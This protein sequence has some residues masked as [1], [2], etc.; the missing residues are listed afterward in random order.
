MTDLPPD[1]VAKAMVDPEWSR[2]VRLDLDVPGLRT[3]DPTLLRESRVLVPVDVQALYVPQ[4]SAE[5]FVRL[6]FA[7]TAPDG[8]PPEPMPEP[9]D[10]GAPRPPGVHLHWALPDALLRGNVDEDRLGLPLLPD[11]WVVLRLVAPIGS[12]TPAV[13]GWVL[14]SDT[15]RVT[16]L[17]DWDGQP[18]GAPRLGRTLTRLDGAA[19]GSIAWT[20]GY[21]ATLGRFAL[22]DPLDGLPER[23]AWHDLATYLVAGWWSEPTADPLDGARTDTS[24]HVRLAE[25]GWSLTTEAEG[26]DED[27]SLLALRRAAFID[28]ANRYSPRVRGVTAKAAGPVEQTHPF[29]PT[30]STLADYAA[31]VLGAEP[32]WPRSTLLHGAVHGVP[33]S[34]GVVAD[35]RPSSGVLDVAL[36]R[37]GDDVAVTLAAAGLG[38]SA[39][40]RSLERVLSAFTGQLLPRLGTPDGLVDVDE[41][42]HAAG[43]LALP[44]GDGGVERVSAVPV[45]VSRP[46]PPPPRVKWAGRSRTEL[47]PPQVLREV[48]Q[49]WEPVGAPVGGEV[50]EVRQPAP[51]FHRPLEP[52]VAV[53]GPRRSLRHGGDGRFS[54]DGN[55]L[56][57]WP[58]Q[59]VEGY[60]QLVDGARLLP[61]VGSGAVPPEVDALARE[62]LTQSPYLRAWLADVAHAQHDLDPERVAARLDAEVLLRFGRQ[63]VYDGAT[64]A[65]GVSSTGSGRMVA[66]ELRRFSLV[67][68]VDSSPV[69]VTAWTQPWVPLW[70]EWTA[71]VEVSDRFDGWSLEAVDLSPPGPLSAPVRVLTGRSPLHDGT[72]STLAR[73]IEAWAVAEDALDLS[74]SGEADEATEAS[75]SGL[76]DAIGNLDVLTAGLDV[77][78]RLLGL[79]ADRLRTRAPDGTLGHVTPVADPLLVACG[80]L[81]LTAAR[82][83]DAFG[84]TLDLPTARVPARDDASGALLLRP[85]LTRPARWLF[86]FTSP[87]DDAEASAG[88]ASPVAGF[89]LPDHLDEALEVFDAAGQPVGQLMDVGGVAWEIA[90]G[91]AG[92]A[93]AGPL[94]DL[95]GG[96]RLLGHLAAGMVAADAAARAGSPVGVAQPESGLSA[97]L[98]A[99]DSTLW[100]VDT[101]AAFGSVAGLVGRPLAV[102]RATLRLEVSDDLAE[103]DLS[104]PVLHASRSAAYRALA[105]RAFTVR[106]GE[107]TRDDDGLV[108]FFVDD[109][110]HHAH[111]V[112]KVVRDGAL[113][114]GRWKG[115]FGPFGSTPVVPSPEPITHPYVVA[116]DELTVHIGQVV[117]LTL[118]MHPTGKVHLTSGVLPRKALRLAD[119]WVR[120]GLSAIAPSARVGPVLVDPDQ[121]RLPKVSS[122]GA[123]QLWTRRT[124]PATWRDDPILAATQSALLPDLPHRVE[125]GYLRIAPEEATP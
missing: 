28:T 116:D 60:A 23:G 95:S 51:R 29:E 6:P 65:F 112:D 22:H 121:V 33:V 100:T 70:L 66:D 92:P 117:R 50:R 123:D 38:A 88:G 67:R 52:V 13:S 21:D 43:F 49:Q 64:R 113:S 24:L 10:P 73:S 106:I 45:D 120:G 96:A 86:R 3:W 62:A 40:R 109:D 56:C 32:G 108:A 59:V 47:L 103:L 98:R 79:P 83:V 19:G 75:L 124:G 15:A 26:G 36:G 61:S 97:F 20:A 104:D 125:E 74:N 111:V 77:H 72:A 99:V 105:D 76:A 78:D 57:R 41:H 82:I 90:P 44:G 115:H 11:R 53:R 46:V 63:A 85:R 107:L 14:E 2:L 48:V 54:P 71:E 58:S 4:G 114:G 16:P 9:F 93:D 8:Q 122:F 12:L 25:L 35:G 7:A 80:T 31:S 89:L 87:A 91:R 5:R 34:G 37:H 102:V 84:R 55:L 119:D 81:R 39:D 68:G 1:L 30:F 69:A 94:H 118:L 42:E 17:S 110:Y 27:R 101:Y 18:S